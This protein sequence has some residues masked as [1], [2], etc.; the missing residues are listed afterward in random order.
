MNRRSF[1]KAFGLGSAAVVV[2]TNIVE[3]KPQPTYREE[4]INGFNK[5]M[6]ATE[7]L[8]LRKEMNESVK[9]LNTNIDDGIMRW[10]EDAYRS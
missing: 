4:F 9:Q 2:G 1:L 10:F 6:T 7:V 5:E 3:A 8:D